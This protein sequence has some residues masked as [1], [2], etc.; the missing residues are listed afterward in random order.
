MQ[1]ARKFSLEWYCWA[2]LRCEEADLALKSTGA[3]GQEVLIELLLALEG[4]RAS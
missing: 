2:L 1:S 4:K 3:D